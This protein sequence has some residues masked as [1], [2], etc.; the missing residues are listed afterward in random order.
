M[1]P[2]NYEGIESDFWIRVH[3]NNLKN[4]LFTL[5]RELRRIHDEE[6]KPQMLSDEESDAV[7]LIDILLCNDIVSLEGVK[8]AMR[9]LTNPSSDLSAPTTDLK[10]KVKDA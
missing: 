6:V 5:I 10:K 2:S 1:N 7:F 9:F 4:E 3:R 8:K